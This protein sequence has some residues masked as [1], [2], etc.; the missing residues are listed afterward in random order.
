MHVIWGE[1]EPMGDSNGSTST[2]GLGSQSSSRRRRGSG[3]TPGSAT[4]AAASASHASPRATPAARVLPSAVQSYLQDVY[5]VGQSSSSNAAVENS[6]SSASS[7]GSASPP[8][9]QKARGVGKASSSNLPDADRGGGAAAAAA[10]LIAEASGAQCLTITEEAEVWAIE[11]VLKNTMGDRLWS[12]GSAKHR[13]GKCRPCHYFHTTAGCLS[14]RDC[15]FCHIPHT[16]KGKSRLGMSKRILCKRVADSVEE[17][18][19]GNLE[20]FR[21]AIDTLASRSPYLRSILEDRLKEVQDRTAGGAG[22]DKEAVRDERIA[23]EFQQDGEL[24]WHDSEST[25][26]HPRKKHILSL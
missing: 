13:E 15:R 24:E 20:G 23:R 3:G 11:E 9:G 10:S 25:S 2:S 5:F 4:S 1:V 8:S 22:G 6:H 12:K 7:A 17:N 16:G 26:R 21:G 18:F 19:Q 14:G